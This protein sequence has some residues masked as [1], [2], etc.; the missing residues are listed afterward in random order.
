[1]DSTKIQDETEVPG[2]V[3]LTHGRVGEELIR[4][5]EM[6]IGKMEK[7]IA[8]SLG[9]GEDP[10]DYRERVSNVL[11]KM[12]RGSIV[13]T[14]LFGGTPSN[15]A[16]VLSKDYSVSVISGLNLPMLIE[17]VNLRQTLSGE[18]LA[19]AVE[20]AGRDGVKN[21]LEILRQQTD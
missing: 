6:I 17:A 14:D 8:V 1:M 15:T 5:A 19:K 7:V 2:I 3:I 9:A 10:G 4:S 16:A 18:E 21:I 13:M 11:A 12:P 20:A